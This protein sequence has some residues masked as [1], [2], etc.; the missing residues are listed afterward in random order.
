MQK[1]K[2]KTDVDLRPSGGSQEGERAPR[3]RQPGLVGPIPFGKEMMWRLGMKL[4][5][6]GNEGLRVGGNKA[7]RASLRSAALRTATV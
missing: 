3:R 6:G 7:S 5:I 1:R 2:K 4:R